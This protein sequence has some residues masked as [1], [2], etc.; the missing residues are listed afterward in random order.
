M[1]TVISCPPSGRGF[2]EAPVP[3]VFHGSNPR[4]ATQLRISSRIGPHSS[5]EASP[6][7]ILHRCSMEQH[8]LRSQ[9]NGGIHRRTTPCR[10]PAGDDGYSREQCKHAYPGNRVEG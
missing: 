7:V 4:K 1:A 8:S 5:S 10:N 6:D 3:T 2:K 9:R